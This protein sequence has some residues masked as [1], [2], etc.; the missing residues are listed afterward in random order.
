V[1]TSPDHGTAYGIAGKNQASEVSFRN[2]IYAAIDI[3]RRKN[4]NFKLQENSLPFTPLRKERFRI[5][6]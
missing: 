4:D 6:F 5:D 1:R 2:A 3:V